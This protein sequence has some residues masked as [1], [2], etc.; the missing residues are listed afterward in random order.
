MH[1]AV[2]SQNFRTVTGHAGR[3]RRF[4]VF[5]VTP[6]EPHAQATTLDLASDMTLRKCDPNHPHPLDDVDYLITGS[7]GSGFVM[8]MA[9]RGVRVLATNETDPLTAVQALLAGCLESVPPHYYRQHA[10]RTCSCDH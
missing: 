8:R 2:T 3:A 5:D 7:A 9:Q 6:A 10:E 1:I 4:L